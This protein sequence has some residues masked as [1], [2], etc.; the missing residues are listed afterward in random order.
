MAWAK[1]SREVYNLR[2]HLRT[3]GGSQLAW[4]V[5]PHVFIYIQLWLPP[6]E[7]SFCVV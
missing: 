6:R 7:I 5:I 1:A 3:C 4:R 2:Y